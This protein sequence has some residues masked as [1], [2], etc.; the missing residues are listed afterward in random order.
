MR[1][2]PAASIDY[3]GTRIAALGQELKGRRFKTSIAEFTCTD[4]AQFG[5]WNRHETE[6][7]LYVLSGSLAFHSEGYEVMRLEPGDSLHFDGRMP[8]A[9]LTAGKDLCRCLYVYAVR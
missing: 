8:H 5:P 2:A 4:I 7:M 1:G 3:P 9:C 6:D